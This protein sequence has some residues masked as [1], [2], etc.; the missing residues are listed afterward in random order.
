MS[1]VGG[2]SVVS[3]GKRKSNF[4]LLRIVA[5]CM[6]VLHHV[7]V[8]GVMH[9]NEGGYAYE[10]WRVGSLANKVWTCLLVPGGEV[11]VALFFMITGYFCYAKSKVSVRRVV[12][13]TW[14]YLT[15]TTVICLCLSDQEYTFAE[16]LH[17]V[18]RLLMPIAGSGYWFATVYVV[19]ILLLPYVNQRLGSMSVRGLFRFLVLVLVLWYAWGRVGPYYDFIRG[20]FFYALGTWLGRSDRLRSMPGTLCV[21]LFVLGWTLCAAAQY[22]V[23]EQTGLQDDAAVLMVEGA[24]LVRTTVA[25]PTCAICLFSLFSSLHMGSREAIN[26]LASCMFGVYLIHDAPLVRHL[27]WEGDTGWG[28]RLFANAWFPVTSLALAIAVLVACVVVD[29]L[30]QRFVEPPLMRLADGI[31]ARI[32]LSLTKE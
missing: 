17:A 25:V 28:T 32:E 7:A 10:V 1:F 16:T 5:M 18:K 13:E 23:A 15:L 26:K 19:I 8:H 27:L 11:G 31:L 9:V 30:R 4:E 2:V 21:V 6:I 12:L 24:T 20:L 22:V 14:F 29:V 3:Q